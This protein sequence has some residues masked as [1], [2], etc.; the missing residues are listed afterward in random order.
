MSNANAAVGDGRLVTVVTEK[1]REAED[2]VRIVLR[3]ADGA[4]LPPFA[5][6]AHV[7]VSLPNGLTRPYSLCNDPHAADR[8]EIAVLLERDGR[9][10]SRAAHERIAVGDR[11]ALRP[12]RNL[13]PLAAEGRAL[14]VAG[15]IGVT[16]LLAMAET[17]AR[18]GR[19]FAFHLCARSAARAAFRAR[20]SEPRF[21]GRVRFHFDD[22]PAEQ[23]FDARAVL[24]AARGASH[25]HVCGPGG[26]MDHVLA[27][28]RDLGWPDDRVH[29]E[30]FSAAPPTPI[31][32]DGDGA[33]ELVLA[34]RGVTIAVAPGVTAAEAML[35]AGAATP[36]SCE[37]GIC[38]TCLLPV[39]EG[40]PDHR[41]HVQ[42]A[43]ERATDR[44]FAPC[45]SR[46]L[47]SRLV[48]DA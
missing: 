14:L 24:A 25:L 15:G 32:G 40:R 18:T 44:W 29:F 12:P 10:G 4:P 27:T 28:A 45:C 11:L 8:Y 2:V 3:P 19:D 13:F 6:G 31:A 16:P 36:L 9:G 46:A 41:D 38:G 30:R 43:A 48:L 35:A 42:T 20:L 17:L 21:A 33:F 47:T 23:R 37:Q 1:I 5:A 34:R 39:L 7:E 26:F 22:G